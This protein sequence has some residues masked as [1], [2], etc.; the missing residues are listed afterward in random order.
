MIPFAF[1]RVRHAAAPAGGRRSPTP[2]REGPA[3]AE[4]EEATADLSLR[5][6]AGFAVA[7]VGIMLAEQTLMNAGVLIVAAN[8][9]RA[10][11]TAASPGSCST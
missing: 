10:D 8:A 4:L 2:P 11:L 1:S 5:H 3:H 9:E 7:V 6:G